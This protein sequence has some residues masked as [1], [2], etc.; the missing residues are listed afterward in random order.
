MKFFVVLCLLCVVSLVQAQQFMFRPMSVTEKMPINSIFNVYQDW[1]GFMWLATANGIVR[2]DGYDVQIMRND[3]HQPTLL[4]SNDIRLF[5]EDCKHIWVGTSHGVTLIDKQT[6]KTSLVEDESLATASVIDIINDGKGNMWILSAHNVYRCNENAELIATYPFEQTINRFHLDRGGVIWLLSAN[7]L[8]LRYN[9]R[10]DKFSRF[11]E[12]KGCN[13]Y[14]MTQDKQGVFWIATWGNGIWK[15]DP[16]ASTKEEMFERQNILNPVRNLP[17]TVFYDVVQDDT[18]GF[19]WALSH[20]GLYVMRINEQ[21]MLEEVNCDTY[22]S[23]NFPIDFYKTY[24]RVAKDCKGNLW[25]A[26]YDQGYIVSFEYDNVENYILND[27]QQHVGLDANVI[28]L[29]KDSKG[30][31]WYNQARYGLCLYDE[32]RRRSV[33]DVRDGGVLYSYDFVDVDP[34]KFGDAVWL[35][36]RSQYS[37]KVLKMTQNNMKV[38]VLEEYDIRD[39]VSVG[40]LSCLAEDYEG[41]IWIGTNDK[42]L[43][44]GADDRKLTNP[45]LSISN[46]VGLSA[47]SLGRVYACSK[48]EVYEIRKDDRPYVRHQFTD[49]ELGLDDN[50]EIVCFCTNH[51]GQVW[52]STSLGLVYLL[53]TETGSVSKHTELYG[54]NGD[55]VLNML[56]D[57]HRLWIVCHKYVVCYDL[58]EQKNTFYSVSDE[59]I[60]I[61]SIRYGAAFIDKTGDLYVG[62][63]KGFF[64]ICVNQQMRC[65]NAVLD[66][67]CISDVKSDGKSVLFSTTNEEESS[68]SEILL[69]PEAR[70]IEIHFSS[71]PYL[72]H[73]YA[74]YA[75]MMEG[76][77]EDWIY[78]ENGVHTAFYNR[79]DKGTYTFKVKATDSYGK[80]MSDYQQLS[81]VSL[82]AWY[83]TYWAYAV[84]VVLI[85]AVVYLIFYFYTKHIEQKN[86]VKFQ[87]ELTQVKLNYFTGISHELFSPLAT[88][89]C[90]TDVLEQEKSCQDG[91]ITILRSNV[92]RLKRLLQQILD[93]R[94]VESGKMSL[95]VENGD[96]TDRVHS[97]IASNFS[98]LAHKKHINLSAKVEDGVWGYVD[99]DKLDKVLIN[100]LSNAIK[101]TPEHK[102][103]VLSM[104]VVYRNNSRILTISI[105]DEGIGIDPKDVNNIFTK[106]YNNKSHQ[107]E[108]NG[109]GLSLCKDLITIHHGTVSVES[110]LNVGSVF[111]I[112]LP[113]DKEAYDENEVFTSSEVQKEAEGAMGE[114]EEVSHLLF[115][116]DNPELRILMKKLFAK[117]Y[118]ITAVSDGHEGLDVLKQQHVDL[119]VCDVMMPGMNGVEF[120]SIL[121]Q[122]SHTSHIPII[123][124]TAKAE[125]EA[126]IE[127]YQVGAESFVAKPFDIN[128]LKARIENLLHSSKVRQKN[129]QKRFDVDLSELE[130][131]VFDE[132]FLKSAIECVESH[133]QES[134]FGIEQMAKELN[135][136]RS[137][138][139]RKLKVLTG[140]TPLDFV[141][142][143]KLKYACRLLKNKTVSI[144]DVAYHLGFSSPKYFTKCFKKELGVTPSEFQGKEESEVE[145]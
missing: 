93:F 50:E 103:V 69:K 114:V 137:T 32:K 18:H 22:N 122:N 28:Y 107:F 88:I 42:L 111:T 38:S 51:S 95:L 34:S 4:S 119:I 141:R 44:K 77:D 29:N 48:R 112:E 20:F 43:Y 54:L 139:S 47:D 136:S 19:I 39:V 99:F 132:D 40:S 142:N 80:W 117:K 91:Q 68:V 36:G 8:L 105:K 2:Y 89:A 130:Y 115:V 90:V 72:S 62:G 120:C 26:A 1:N 60:S 140:L 124:L 134:E 144:S 66:R 35:A 27:M 118:N 56:M 52:F 145:E 106:F 57:N 61:S 138:L 79:L 85:L 74:K 92:N 59:N 135:M 15:F 104:Y 33:Y 133:I 25:L 109:I 21:G 37:T 129:F 67:V 83:E 11:V 96:V 128:I 101:Y 97:I 121:K 78:V 58:A 13:L 55:V 113:I 12:L 110:E 6:F 100:L 46:V 75:Y 65:N 63:H 143:I 81:I 10:D 70:N 24:S 5:A 7:G 64:R 17:E 3:Y 49:E 16:L 23:K 102:S 73:R 76:V 125:A 45:D 116:D 9:E 131:Q 94:K 127:C 14:Q 82:P 98:P 53:N 84:Y 71:F 30:V 41:N 31:I 108:S 123:M 126:Q 87:E 86:M